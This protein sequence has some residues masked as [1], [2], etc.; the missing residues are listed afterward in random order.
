MGKIIKR[1]IVAII[2]LLLLMS[3]GFLLWAQISVYPAFPEAKAVYERAEKQD[4]FVVFG[5]KKSDTAFV[6]YPGGL[7][8]PAAY[9]IML[10][11]LADRGILV[12]LAPM[13]LDFAFLD[14]DRAK[15]ALGIYPNVKKWIIAGH[16]LGGAMA[17]EYVKRHPN[18]FSYLVLLASYPAES[19]SL[20]NSDIKVLSIYG[21]ED[22]LDR[23]IFI[24]SAARLPSDT[25][26][27]EIAGANHAGFGHYGP[28]KKDGEAKIKRDTQQDITVKAIY[29]FIYSR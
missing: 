10:K 22:I 20:R 16:S 21:T 25:K 23:E 7:V 18:D 28:Q 9:S 27:L 3:A 14:I 19:T 17:C 29:D 2:A 26:F 13:P 1:I 5:D 8:D 6:F 4:D 12:L 15:K 11:K 24:S